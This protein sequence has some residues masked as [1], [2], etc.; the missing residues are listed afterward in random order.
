LLVVTCIV[1]VFMSHHPIVATSD[2]QE[3]VRRLV[4]LSRISAVV[5]GTLMA[6][7]LITYYALTAF[8]R[9]R[10]STRPLV[11]LGTIAYGA[12]I[13]IM[14]IAALVSGFVVTQVAVLTPHDTPVDLQINRQ[15]FILCGILNQACANFGVF[16]ISAG[17]ALWAVDLL[18]DRGTL[19]AIGL[20]G[21]VVGIV[22]VS[23]LG[24][25]A[26]RLD[27]HGM[28]EVLFVQS[29]WNLAI[30]A[31]MIREARRNR[32]PVGEMR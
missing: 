17:I 21:L 26:I 8:A 25:G 14:L 23:A 24:S 11:R 15:L 12:G 32:Q 31:W 29:A 22:P 30:A 5:H 10:G 2:I 20:L 18:R 3:A 19:R 6:L 27:V 7:L 9:Q 1:L 13:V 4:A 28:G 16:A